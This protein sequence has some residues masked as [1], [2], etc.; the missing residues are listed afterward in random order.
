VEERV[1]LGDWLKARKPVSGMYSLIVFAVVPAR[2]ISD[3]GRALSPFSI[4]EDGVCLER[5]WAG[6]H[7]SSPPGG[8][9]ASCAIMVTCY[10]R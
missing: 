8:D 5:G 10:S 1:I 4:S 7:T 6:L 9:D 2:P 3:S